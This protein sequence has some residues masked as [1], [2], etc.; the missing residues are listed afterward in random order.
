MLRLCMISAIWPSIIITPGWLLYCRAVA[1]G[2]A[3]AVPHFCSTQFFKT[4]SKGTQVCSRTVPRL[5]GL[6]CTYVHGDILVWHRGYLKFEDIGDLPLEPIQPNHIAFPSRS[7]GKSAAV[8][9][10][11]QATWFNKFGWL[12]YD[13]TQDCFTCCKKWLLFGFWWLQIQSQSMQISGGA[14]PQ[15]P[16]HKCALHTIKTPWARDSSQPIVGP[17]QPEIAAYGPVL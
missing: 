16:L 12:H 15:T 11:F 3:M 14:Y 10:S 6:E 1:T 17:H 2:A 4:R 9:R 8:N 5:P 13:V 7:F